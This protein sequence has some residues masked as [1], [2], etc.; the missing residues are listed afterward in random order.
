[1]D[2]DSSVIDK[3]FLYVLDDYLLIA[4]FY[5]IFLEYEL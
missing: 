5:H 2:N 3:E 4:L 1:V